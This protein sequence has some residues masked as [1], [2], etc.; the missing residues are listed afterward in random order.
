MALLNLLRK[1]DDEQSKESNNALSILGKLGPV[2]QTLIWALLIAYILRRFAQPISTF[3]VK[4]G[5]R[6]GKLHIKTPIGEVFADVGPQ[7][8]DE[9]V[10]KAA[11]KVSAQSLSTD[12]PVN[13]SPSS[14]T[15]NDAPV[16]DVRASDTS[17]S[18]PPDIPAFSELTRSTAHRIRLAYEAEDFVIRTLQLEF[19]TT[20]VQNVKT[21]TGINMDGFFT[22]Q[23]TPCVIEVKLLSPKTVGGFIRDSLT[24]L[25][26][27]LE[28]DPRFEQ[29]RIIMAL[30]YIEELPHEKQ[31]K[32]ESMLFQIDSRVQVRWFSLNELRDRFIDVPRG[33]HSTE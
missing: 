28:R 32:I 26:S 27:G 8:K 13:D 4:F 25:V 5:E 6:L 7:S 3:L 14:N 18:P 11:E 1:V 24:R 9:Q 33:D 21:R 30:V 16:N 31:R 29:A 15:P 10:S 12:V 22:I 2:F 20:I 19:G 17:A 23:D